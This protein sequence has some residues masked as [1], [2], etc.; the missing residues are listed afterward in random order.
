MHLK[1]RK[2][3]ALSAAGALVLALGLSSLYWFPKKPARNTIFDEKDAAAVAKQALSLSGP[4]VAQKLKGGFSGAQLFT[5]TSG[6]KKYVVRFLKHPSQKT[7]QDEIELSNI[8]A[9]GGY[10]PQIYYDDNKQG[11][12]IIEFL[13]S[14][15]A[16]YQQHLL[17]LLKPKQSEQLYVELAQLLQKIHSGP[18]FPKSKSI[19]DKTRS[20]MPRIKSKANDDV[21]LTRIE[22]IVSIIHRAIG[23]HLS[24]TPSHNDLNPNNLRF[25]GRK[26]KAIDFDDA[27]Q[28]D[29]YYDLATV[30]IYYCIFPAYEKIL[31][32]AYLKRHPTLQER[33]KLY[34]M[35]QMA[36]INEA[37]NQLSRATEKIGKY[38]ALQV[39]SWKGLLKN[40][41]EGKVNLEDPND[42][43]RIAKVLINQVLSN[44]ESQE[45]HNSVELLSKQD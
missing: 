9:K 3:V 7:R 28:Q 34:L 27:A 10:G 16:S 33:A 44:S 21:P 18:K 39:L 2:M 15:F 17:T 22:N 1:K 6:S 11:V 29:P 14:R 23:P 41:S 13:P 30:A 25:L 20:R 32:S 8:A 38:E 5:V 19:F 31:L 12:I 26:T 4:V 45:F 24:P 40:F 43:L 36:R 42:Q 37:L 35:K